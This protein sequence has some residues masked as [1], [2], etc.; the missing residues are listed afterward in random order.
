MSGSSAAASKPQVSSLWMTVGRAVVERRAGR[1]RARARAST[2]KLPAAA[3]DG[4]A[5]R[6]IVG[7]RGPGELEEE[8]AEPAPRARVE[9]DGERGRRLVVGRRKTR[10]TAARRARAAA[11]ALNIKSSAK[12]T[13]SGGDGVLAPRG[14]PRDARERG[15]LLRGARSRRWRIRRG[16]ATRRSA[17]PT[18]GCTRRRSRARRSFPR[19][20]RATREN[21]RNGGSACS[22]SST[23]TRTTRTSSAARAR[24]CAPRSSGCRACTPRSSPRRARSA[25]SRRRTCPRRSGRRGWR[26]ASTA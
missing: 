14:R 11:G 10:R 23:S 15:G 6:R 16:C 2:E 26:R 12:F 8:K 22:P 3:D 18:A 4:S 13:K 20:R 1:A 5:S 19:C 17:W 24:R 21:G 9:G 25:A 7:R